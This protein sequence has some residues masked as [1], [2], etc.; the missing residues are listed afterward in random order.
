[1]RRRWYDSV[2]VEMGQQAE[3]VDRGDLPTCCPDQTDGPVQGASRCAGAVDADQDMK[4]EG[5]S[6]S[7]HSE[8][9]VSPITSRGL[10]PLYVPGS[11]SSTSDAGGLGLGLRRGEGPRRHPDR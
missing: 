8:R 4:G 3:G 5:S 7:V 10:C 6:L 9:V 2:I 11:W 1:M